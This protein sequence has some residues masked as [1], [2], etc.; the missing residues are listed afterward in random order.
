[1]SMKKKILS[2]VEFLYKE[3]FSFKFLILYFN[4]KKKI[5]Q[6][7]PKSLEINNICY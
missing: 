6:Q 2:Y 4:Y 3:S 1:M 7:D 5:V